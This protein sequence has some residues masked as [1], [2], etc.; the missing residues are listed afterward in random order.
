[1]D[2][3]KHKCGWRQKYRNMSKCWRDLRPCV[4]TKASKSLSADGNGGVD[5]RFNQK[6]NLKVLAALAEKT[7]WTPKFR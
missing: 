4:N 5:Q 6:K 7:V 3:E 2:V 1:M